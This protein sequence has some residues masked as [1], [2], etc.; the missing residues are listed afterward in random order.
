MFTLHI[1]KLDLYKTE[2]YSM[3]LLYMG[4]IIHISVYMKNAFAG[5]TKYTNNIDLTDVLLPIFA[6]WTFF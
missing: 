6:P 1:V 3:S 4:H 5:F 2:I